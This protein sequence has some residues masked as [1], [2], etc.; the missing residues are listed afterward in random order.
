[1]VK[2]IRHNW[3]QSKINVT[4]EKSHKIPD[5]LVHYPIR[6]VP[7]VKL[8]LKEIIMNFPAAELEELENRLK[9][10]GLNIIQAAR[11]LA[12]VYNKCNQN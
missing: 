9:F 3:P 6:E 7:D 10:F 5:W 4:V 11:D 1:M 8:R 12:D 2:Q